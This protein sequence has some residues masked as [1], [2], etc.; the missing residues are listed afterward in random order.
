MGE[1]FF[2]SLQQNIKLFLWLPSLCAIFRAIFIYVYHPYKNLAGKGKIIWECFRFGFWW[3]LDI[4]AY[5]LLI[6]LFLV[7]LPFLARSE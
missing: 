2:L 7:T 1:Q 5:Q 3:G 4:N 6:L